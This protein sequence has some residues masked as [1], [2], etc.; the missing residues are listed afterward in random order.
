MDMVFPAERTHFFPGV[1]KIGAPISGPR[2]ADTNF[3]DT[4]IFLI[5]VLRDLPAPPLQGSDLPYLVR[6]NL[7]QAVVLDVLILLPVF[8][9]SF[10][11]IQ[12]PPALLLAAYVVLLGAMLRLPEGPTIKKFN[13]ARN[14]K[15]APTCYR[16]P[17]WPDPEFPQKNTEKIPLGQKFWNPKKI[18]QKYRKKYQKCAFLVFWGVFFRYF[19]GILGVNSGSPEFRAGG[20]FFGI[21][22]G[23]SGSGHFG[24]L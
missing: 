23:N 16:A 2:I 14:F 15:N 6:F 9:S 22:R 19:R 7:A 13:L 5:E 1:H 17:R 12:F 11:G 4:R 18:P 20:Y 24:A 10:I 21:F 3:T 8:I